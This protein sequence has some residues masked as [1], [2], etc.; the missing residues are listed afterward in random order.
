MKKIFWLAGENSGD[1]HAANILTELNKRKIKYQHFG[2][3]GSRMESKGFSSLFEFEKFSV[4]GF[5]EVIKHLF[6]FL[7]VE[8]KIKEILTKQKPSLLILIDYPGLNLR[9]ARIATELKIPVLYYICPQF[10][11]W[12]SKR[13]FK[14]R[15]FTSHV[16]CILPFEKPL[17][18]QISVNATYTGH[19]IAE[20]ISISINREEFAVK[21]HLN[22]QKK[23][24]SFFPGSRDIEIKKLLPIFLETIK[25]FENQEYL[26]LISKTKTIDS[27]LFDNI[28]QQSKVKNLKIIE[29]DN[30][31]MMKY[32]DFLVITS[33]TA[34]LEAAFLETP[35][36]IVYKTSK[37][38]YYI[39]KKLVKLK[40]IGL[41]NIILN[42]LVVPE[43]I[44]EEAN[45]KRIYSEI[46]SYFQSPEK[47]ITMK[48]ELSKIHNLL[49]KKSSSKVVS[50]LIE[51]LTNE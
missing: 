7:S 40:L 31:E 24:I 51:K 6:F 23:W 4:M 14:L 47:M 27:V 1:L 5:L 28:V 39:G 11:A 29:S 50:D 34:T 44:Q 22:L 17:L 42:K 36:I 21:H 30:Y 13:I 46:T 49:G 18:D 35:L 3:G 32:S 19:P 25:M 48:N 10:W 15:E 37:I 33:G 43:L 20:E 26:F 12:K 2:V 9:I 8:K 45:P 16:A 41:P 38:S